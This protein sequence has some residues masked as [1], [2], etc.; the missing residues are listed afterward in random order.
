MLFL[1]LKQALQLSLC[2]APMS[3]ANDKDGGD[4]L[5]VCVR[6]YMQFKCHKGSLV[7]A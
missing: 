7:F 6:S 5:Q 1:W 2:R 4:L 3:P